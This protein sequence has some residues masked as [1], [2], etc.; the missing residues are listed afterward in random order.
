MTPESPALSYPFA[1]IAAP[2]PFLQCPPPPPLPAPTVYP[3]SPGVQLSVRVRGATD[4]SDPA[5]IGGVLRGVLQDAVRQGVRR[6][7]LEQSQAG[8]AAVVAELDASLTAVGDMFGAMCMEVARA[9][10]ALARDS[11]L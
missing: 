3:L 5:A 4:C 2:H 11:A 10:E 1:F 6:A 8:R 9:R 7:Q